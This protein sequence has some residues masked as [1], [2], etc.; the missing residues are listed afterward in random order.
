MTRQTNYDPRWARHGEAYV[1]VAD[2]GR[3]RIFKRTG[4]RFAPELTELEQ[5]ERPNAHAHARDLT[6]DLTGRR[7]ATT[8]GAGIGRAVMR[9]GTNS[10]YDPH[11]VEIERFARQVAARLMELTRQTSI[12]ELV[13]I[14][15]PQFLGVLRRELPE[16]LH[17][18]VSREV[19]RDLTNALTQPIAQAAFSLPAAPPS[20]SV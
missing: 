14:A 7:Y 6:T 11:A 1:V 13:L 9:H 16:T 20:A 18:L 15:E 12:E 19:S 2:S 10:D 17:K 4:K 3:A 8:T 5:L